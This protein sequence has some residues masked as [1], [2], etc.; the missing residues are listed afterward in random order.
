MRQ[1]ISVIMPAYNEAENITPYLRLVVEA[2]TAIDGVTNFEIIVVDDHSSDG[3]FD[4]VA[5]LKDARIRCIRL[6]HRR[7]SHIAVRAG[8]SEARG[9]AV[10]LMSADGQDD[11]LVLKSMIAQWQKGYQVVWACRQDRQLEPLFYRFLTGLSYSIMAFACQYSSEEKDLM[12]KADFF[13]LDRVVVDALNTCRE[14]HTSVFGLIVWGGFK[15]TTVEYIRKARS[16][17]HSKWNLKKRIS[18][19]KDWV[20]AFSGF[21]V[22][23]VFLTGVLVTFFAVGCAFW[24]RVSTGHFS[25]MGAVLLMGGLQLTAIGIIGEY[26][27]Y[28]LKEAR[29]RPLYFIERRS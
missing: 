29:Q 8:L 1:L 15:Q 10:F 5:S 20:L 11:P 9:E 7:G 17:G 14:S 3:T 6:S 24:S 13:L 18:L 27:R 26:V 16:S 19:A 22:L 2:I 21:P 28:A 25:L 12:N 4:G 23:L